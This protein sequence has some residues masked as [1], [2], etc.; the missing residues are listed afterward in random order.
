MWQWV[1]EAVRDGRCGLRAWLLGSRVT[2]VNDCPA[3]WAGWAALCCGR[4][5]HRWTVT[6]SESWMYVQCGQINPRIDFSSSF[7]FAHVQINKMNHF[8][9]THCAEESQLGMTSR[10]GVT[11]TLIH[12]SLLSDMQ[13]GKGQV[14]YEVA[15][16]TT[17]QQVVANH[18]Q[19]LPTAEGRITLVTSHI[20][21]STFQTLTSE[22]LIYFLFFRLFIYY[23]TSWLIWN[24]SLGPH[25]LIFHKVSFPSHF[26]PKEFI[27]HC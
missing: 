27:A 10:Q 21:K 8:Y 24:L 11:S 18:R 14:N 13:R 3:E 5:K 25:P 15:N 16:D 23:F 2:G 1:C 22:E 19:R 7:T 20:L 6:A 26:Q 4:G 17:D 9:H 12:N